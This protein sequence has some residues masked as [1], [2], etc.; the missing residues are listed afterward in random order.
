MEPIMIGDLP[1]DTSSPANDA[2]PMD[3]PPNAV[4]NADGTVTL[5]LEW[6]CQVEMRKAGTSEVAATEPYT[7][8]ILR[9]LN[10]ADVR[11]MIAAKDSSEMALALSSG[12]GLG[13]LR[14][15]QTVLDA[16]DEADANAVISEFL[17][18]AGQG[19]PARATEAEG[20]I[21]L[22]MLYP[23]ADESGTIH[24]QMVFKRMTAVMRKQAVAAKSILDWGVA[25]ATGLTPKQG[26]ALVDIMDGIDA[27]AVNQV[28]LFL[29]GSG[30]RTGRP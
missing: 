30:P 28:M 16:R 4:L 9:R 17:G 13:K 29:F 7:V 6:P 27:L 24:D 14:R 18:A 8:L 21:T 3:L 23:V 2:P 15:L 20:V 19:L 1:I 22:P 5:T 11:A 25:H 26:S 12:L 10:G